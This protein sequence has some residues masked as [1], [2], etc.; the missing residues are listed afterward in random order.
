MWGDREASPAVAPSLE[1]V[2]APQWAAE[3]HPSK[4]ISLHP[5]AHF[6]TLTRFGAEDRVKGGGGQRETGSDNKA[7]QKTDLKEYVAS[8]RGWQ[9]QQSKHQECVPLAAPWAVPVSSGR[10]AIWGWAGV[11]S[12]LPDLLITMGITTQASEFFPT[13]G[14]VTVP[15]AEGCAQQSRSGQARRRGW[16]HEA[17]SNPELGRWE[18]HPHP[19]RAVMVD[20]V[21]WQQSCSGEPGSTQGKGLK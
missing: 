18:G 17:V 16:F 9:R 10:S 19:V 13:G 8:P 3:D 6:S 21:N 4:C 12:L 14:K 5:T 1:G 7:S 2:P 11:P 15:R 20:R